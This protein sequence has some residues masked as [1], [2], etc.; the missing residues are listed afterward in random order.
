MPFFPLDR[1]RD[2]K[3][4]LNMTARRMKTVFVKQKKPE[5][6]SYNDVCIKTFANEVGSYPVI[7]ILSF[8]C[9]GSFAYGNY[10][11]FFHNDIQLDPAKRTSVIRYWGGERN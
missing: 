1:N 10:L 6:G 5:F 8:A 3:M 2:N 4:M 11:L 7:F 9:V